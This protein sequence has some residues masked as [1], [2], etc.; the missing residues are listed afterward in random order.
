MK[1][2]G[3]ISRS[4]AKRS[5]RP[6]G[7]PTRADAAPSAETTV[8]SEAERQ[9]VLHELQVHQEELEAQNEELRETQGELEASRDRYADLYDFAPIGYVTLDEKG[10][11]REINLTGAAMLGRERSRLLGTLFS[12]SVAQNDSKTFHDHLRQCLPGG[13]PATTELSLVAR[14]RDPIRVQLLSVPVRGT[15][16]QATFYRTAI[17]DI[18]ARQRAEDAL[19][20]A[21]DELE[22][23]VKKRTAVLVEAVAALRDEI[24]E[25]KAAEKALREERALLE[26]VIEGTTDAIFAKDSQGRFLLIN[27]AGAR[28]IGK[29]VEEVIGKTQDEVLSPE[30]ARLFDE[31]DRI[32]LREQTTKTFEPTVTF[33]GGTRTFLVTKGVL[34]DLQGNVT[35]I[36]G[37]ARDVTQRRLAE[38]RLKRSEKGLRAFAA[39]L[40]CAREEEDVRI[41][42]EVHDNLGQMLT[43]LTLDLRWMEDQVSA[44]RDDTPRASLLQKIGMMMKQVSE[45]IECV[46]RIAAELRPAVLDKLGIAEAIETE[47]RQFEKR[48]G[49]RC[50][51]SLPEQ[52][53][54]L[55][56]NSRLALFRI[57]Q[58]ALNNIAR[59]A[60]ATRVEVHLKQENGRQALIVKDNGRGISD[61]DIDD[62]KALGLLGMRE[63]AVE[64]GG[65]TTFGGVPGGGTTVMVSIP[66]GKRSQCG[67]HP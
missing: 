42:R 2:L 13:G 1:K 31:D 49:I 18:T 7:S 23:Q 26:A 34:R 5:V 59:H 24:A 32:I 15:T 9:S 29:S 10:H 30:I 46:Q 17:T 3:E 22:D 16:S 21:R 56:E 28:H 45:A 47:A 33:P 64:L 50:E 44:Q 12:V 67:D 62:P 52:P 25:R 41:A 40:R 11:I 48:T 37:I 36:L 43:G 39:R 60:Q 53:T 61:N 27:S 6:P 4:K 66:L 63:R 57:F 58:E 19:R 35:G 55:N 14:D 38:E 65:E 20:Q 54:A 8:Q 51:L